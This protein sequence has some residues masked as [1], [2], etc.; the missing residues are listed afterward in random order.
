MTH[1]HTHTHT[2]AQINIML[3]LLN[4]SL[5]FLKRQIMRIFWWEW[6][7]NCGSLVWEGTAVPIVPQQQPK[8]SYQIF[9]ARSYAWPET[10]TLPKLDGFDLWGC[11]LN[12][13]HLEKSLLCCDLNPAAGLETWMLPMWYVPSIPLYLKIGK[14]DW[15][16][17][18][19]VTCT[20][21]SKNWFLLNSTWYFKIGFWVMDSIL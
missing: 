20:I 1:T 17:T 7:S 2:D 4:I 9:P 10:S 6:D 16:K 15:L 18:V 12:K 3:I 5:I 8:S 19:H 11:P 13:Q 14:I 21:Q